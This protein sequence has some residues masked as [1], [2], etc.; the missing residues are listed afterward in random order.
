MKSRWAAT[1]AAI[2]VVLVAAAAT[3]CQKKQPPVVRPMPP[4]TTEATPTVP[5]P[6]PAPP[7]AVVDQPVVPVE[8]IKED[9]MTSRS[10]DQLNRDSP[11]RPVFFEYDSAE[12]SSDGQGVLDADAV[13]FKKY[14]T[15]VVT[16]EGHCDERGTAEYN[17]A[18]GERR[19]VAARTY[20]VSLGISADRI[21]TVSYGKEFP[22]DPGHDEAAYVK[23]RRAHFVITAK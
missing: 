3:G 15:W 5:T 8:P 22:F 19:A 13:L 12:I 4:P 14:S 20:L 10:L 16:I 7:Q 11:L 2:V 9:T 18:L 21:R 17:L 1:A 6:P 23:N